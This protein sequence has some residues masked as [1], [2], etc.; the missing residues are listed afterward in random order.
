MTVPTSIQQHAGT[1]GSLAVPENNEDCSSNYHRCEDVTERENSSTNVTVTINNNGNSDIIVPPATTEGV[2]KT[3]RQSAFTTT[4]QVDSVPRST[5]VAYWKTLR[6][7][8]LGRQ[9]QP[10]S[11]TT[12]PG[13]HNDVRLVITFATVPLFIGPQPPHAPVRP[14]ELQEAIPAEMWMEFF[15]KVQTAARTTTPTTVRTTT[16]ITLVALLGVAQILLIAGICTVLVL[17]F[18]GISEHFGY[19]HIIVSY[20]MFLLYVYLGTWKF[21]L[22][23]DQQRTPGIQAVCHQYSPAF[24]EQSDYYIEFKDCT[25]GL[26][27]RQKMIRQ[28]NDDEEMVRKQNHQHL[29]DHHAAMTTTHHAQ[30]QQP[31]NDD[32]NN[33][34]TTSS[35]FATIV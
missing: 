15:E 17:L 26:Q 35:H 3:A 12:T 9:Q 33:T 13:K 32:V 5:L 2:P 22:D 20:L 21:R 28:L 24:E 25:S 14:R 7:N 31:T 10:T 8:A 29:K 27:F 4:H 16:G 18:M 23:F 11:S 34:A 30:Q 19:F 6:S 1:T